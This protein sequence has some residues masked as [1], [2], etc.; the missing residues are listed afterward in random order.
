MSMTLCWFGVDR[1]SC[2]PNFSISLY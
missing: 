2:S 1:A